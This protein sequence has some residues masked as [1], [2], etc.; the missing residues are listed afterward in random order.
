MQIERVATIKSFCNNNN[1]K[2]TTK[3]T[4]SAVRAK[5]ESTTVSENSGQA[6]A[7]TITT[8]TRTSNAT[9][10]TTTT[11]KSKQSRLFYFDSLPSA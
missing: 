8:T 1:W 9:Q 5:L 2:Q 4:M 7:T 3:V 6:T 10:E 11:W